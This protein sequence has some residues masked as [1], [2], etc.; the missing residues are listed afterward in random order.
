MRCDDI[1][2]LM[3]AHVDGCLDPVGAQRLTDHLANCAP[4]RRE[5]DDLQRT[6]KLLRQ[7]KPVAP[8]PDLTARIH[9][10]IRHPH[11]S[12]IIAFLSLPQTRVALVASL[13]VIL[14]TY[15]IRQTRPA[16]ARPAPAVAPPRMEARAPLAW[17]P[18]A[19]PEQ[20]APAIAAPQ[21]ASEK[22]AMVEEGRIGG[23]RPD[24]SWDWFARQVVDEAHEPAASMPV[25]ADAVAAK[26]ESA[27]AIYP[28]AAASAGGGRGMA[29]PLAGHASFARPGAAMPVPA[30]SA[31]GAMAGEREAESRRRASAGDYVFRT[32]HPAELA[33]IVNRHAPRAEAVLKD[34]ADG[35]RMLAVAA[36]RKDESAK[37]AR[38]TTVEVTLPP[39]AIPALLEELRQAGGM[40]VTTPA[41]PSATTNILVR[42]TFLP[43]EP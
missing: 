14:T 23:S 8:P 42:F 13:L 12:R 36:V 29:E 1:R 26:S 41:T 27:P 22:P 39:S 37:T 6:V 28:Q 2:E 18:L 35:N 16:A 40:T 3:S 17:A 33:A 19:E 9:A 38:P 10:R 21:L 24:G 31:F 30:S 43:V 25:A 4:C 15:G 20:T 5:W 11:P 32:E 7:M 34:V